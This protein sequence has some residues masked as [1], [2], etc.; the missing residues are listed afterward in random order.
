M[1]VSVAARRSF[2]GGE[3]PADDEWNRYGAKGETES[4]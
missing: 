2:V 4:A 3:P 1:T